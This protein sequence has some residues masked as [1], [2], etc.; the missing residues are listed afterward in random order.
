[1]A[2]HEAQRAAVRRVFDTDTTT[3]RF[4]VHEVDV[5]AERARVSFS[6]R[7]SDLIYRAEVSIRDWNDVFLDDMDDV[8]G[9]DGW[10]AT[11]V[12]VPVVEAFDTGPKSR[13][14]EADG[15]VTLLVID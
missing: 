11:A 14:T 12:L 1:M 7:N 8:D 3:K 15:S 9:L 6:E 5:D 4:V 13:R 10:A 2:E